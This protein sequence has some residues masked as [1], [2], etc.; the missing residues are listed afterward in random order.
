MEGDDGNTKVKVIARVRPILTQDGISSG[1]EECLVKMPLEEPGKTILRI[2]THINQNPYK[3]SAQYKKDSSGSGLKEYW[4]DQAVFS[5]DVSSDSYM[6]NQSFYRSIGPEVV[7]D[8]YKGFNMC[9]LAYGQT[10]TGKTF[11]MMGHDAEQDGI[12]P[13]LARD[14]LQRRD[15]LVLQRINSEVSM[16]Y[17]ELYN[18]QARDLLTDQHGDNKGRVREHPVRG[19]YVEGLREIQVNEFEDFMT[20]LKEG[21]ARRST[22]ATGS[23]KNSSRSHAIVTLALKQTRFG[24]SR[25][26]TGDEIGYAKEQLVS[27][28]KLV[29]LAGSERM[30]KTKLYSQ[31][32]RM[33]EGTLINQSLSVLGRC[34]NLLSQ[35]TSNK[36]SKMHVIPYRE[37]VLTYLLKEN[38]AGNSKSYMI[39]CISPSDFEETLHTLNYANQVKSIKTS[40]RTNVV[41][42]DLASASEDGAQKDQLIESL[43]SEI[44]LISSKLA[45]T[46]LSSEQSYA[47]TLVSY[48]EAELGKL[49]FE[50]RFVKSIIAQKEDLILEL[51]SHMRYIDQ[52]ASSSIEKAGAML[53]KSH[54]MHT[55]MT[56]TQAELT[57]I[58]RNLA[59]FDPSKIL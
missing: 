36:P 59:S 18:E 50:N 47:D 6:E 9:I 42:L 33:K 19:P 34:I 40:A 55:L 14:I 32:S 44:D 48:L 7:D 51:K 45:D 56:K 16:T 15:Q 25:G 28:I 38:L 5:A 52:D 11:T 3:A 53:S 12:I 57:T 8:L 23:N 39:F 41:Q 37:S 30:A 54:F 21:N 31:Q 13:M 24:P 49:K 4:F 17:V 2:P 22:A 29:D 43:R 46:T 27:N 1:E 20:A 35:N 26:K 58:D 10:G